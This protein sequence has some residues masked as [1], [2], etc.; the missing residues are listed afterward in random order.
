MAFLISAA[1]SLAYSYSRPV[2]YR[3]SATLLTSAM[4]A[5]DR[6]SSDADIQ[7]VAIQ[8]QILLGH[9]L[10]AE[11]LARLKASATDKSLLSLKP[12]DIQT[13]LTV[14]PVPE[15]NLVEI[16]A[17]G[18]NPKFLPLLINTWIDV[19]LNARAEDVK[20]L[21]GNTQRILEDECNC[22]QG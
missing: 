11:T 14:E 18:S 10:A 17:E 8:R 6:E 16:S 21:A 20:K 3:S 19:Y 4:T 5:I 1:I 7:H 12:S 22:K 13:L 15:T 2:V 9:E